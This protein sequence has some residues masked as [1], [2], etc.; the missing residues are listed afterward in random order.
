MRAAGGFLLAVGVLFRAEP[1][2]AQSAIRGTVKSRATST[3][4]PG[5]EIIADSSGV[6][7]VRAN[8]QGEFLLVGFAPGPITVRVRA[9]GYKPV[10]VS[11]LMG[12]QDTL[13]LDIL[14]D[15]LPQRLESVDVVANGGR[16]RQD[17]ISR[18]EIESV[19]G[20]SSDAYAIVKQL[21]PGYLRSRVTLGL[22][23]PGHAVVPAPGAGSEPR[24]A[25]GISSS[26]ADKAA[27]VRSAEL[28][29]AARNGKPLLPKVSINDGPLEDLEG[30]R[31]VE[32]TSVREIRFVS[33]ILA[34]TR[35]GE[36]AAGGVI[37][38]T[39]R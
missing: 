25:V 15:P 3:A 33:P 32:A 11:A 36:G 5:S 19:L 39:L 4:V 23:D 12:A 18:S 16:P 34:T 24:S 13:D 9:I 2:R 8:R 35:Y 30:L 26:N 10:V 37:V 6:R 22:G 27:A 29:A 7:P 14:L 1:V 28:T 38:V 31:R 20:S 17:V 21:R